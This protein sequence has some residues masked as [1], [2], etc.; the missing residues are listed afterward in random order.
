MISGLN[1][2][3][4]IL[5]RT[6]H[7]Q[8]EL[9]D[10]DGLSIRTEVFVGGK[11]VATR[12]TRLD[13]DV[14]A[15][16][17]PG[18]LR[19][20]MKAH[21]SKT[22]ESFVSRARSYQRRDGEAPMPEAG[23]SPAPPPE[24]AAAPEP[25]PVG[26]P[27]GLAPPSPAAR[28]AVAGALRVRRLFGRFRQL[29]G[30]TSAFPEDFGDRLEVMSRAFAWMI[31]SSLF[32]EIRIDEQ[33]RC[34]LLKEQID[35]WLA[36]DRDRRQAAQIWAGIVTFN[37]YLSEINH[38]TDL[39]AYDQQMLVWA[40]DEVQRQGMTDEVFKGIETLYGLDPRLDELLED[41]HDVSGRAWIAHLRHVLTAV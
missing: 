40:L 10:Q 11:V 41:P 9:S 15:E 33:M 6:F 29:M 26:T 17:E 23:G 13:A 19:A 3:V 32:G 16:L 25:P 7:F 5:G 31:Q 35:E 37:N 4:E 18:D 28:E 27:K 1:Q 38:R 21:H 8:T 24:D 30:P 34:H 36:S 2:E 14:P 12:E 20:R 39:Q 22:L